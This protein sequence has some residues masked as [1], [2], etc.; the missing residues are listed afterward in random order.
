MKI[1]KQ[2][3]G[4]L[5]VTTLVALSLTSN[6]YAQIPPFP[7]PGDPGEPPT[8]EELEAQYQAW[9]AQLE[10]NRLSVLPNLHE[11]RA[12]PDGSP[13]LFDAADSYQQEQLLL[14]AE[15]NQTAYD[16]AQ[17]QVTN[18]SASTGEPIV[19]AAADDRTVTLIGFQ[20]D[21]PVLFMAGDI[22]QAD[23][24]STDEIWP[25][26]GSGA[27]TARVTHKGTLHGSTPQ[28]FALAA[29]GNLAQSKP[30]LVVTNILMTATN[31]IALTW[32]SVVG[33]NYI[34]QSR[35]HVA[36]GSWANATGEINAIKPTVAVEL[37]ISITNA[38]R[39]YRV[40]E[41]E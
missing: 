31:K 7:D 23:T 37:P 8:Q 10:T 33:Q 22:F 40:A 5:V 12:L 28:A 19:S 36:S 32:Q 25:G 26:G 6:L 34:V 1:V 13:W 3:I 17:I 2:I 16:A 35:D 11:P 9:L 21:M 24:I 38:H 4:R 27:Y 41:V 14:L 39:F 29:S 20:Y 15:E 18:W 30:A